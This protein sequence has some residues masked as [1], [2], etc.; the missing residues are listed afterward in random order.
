[1]RAFGLGGMNSAIVTYPIN[2]KTGTQ[3]LFLIGVTS[4]DRDVSFTST[5]WS[6]LF[7]PIKLSQL[8]RNFHRP[9]P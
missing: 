3:N 4:C 9:G 6:H 2:S 7:V 1:M 5:C 8:P